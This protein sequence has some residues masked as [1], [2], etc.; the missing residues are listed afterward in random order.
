MNSSIIVVAYDRPASLTRLLMSLKKAV[1]KNFEQVRL[2]ISID[3]GGSES[4]K[5]IAEEFVWDYGAKRVIHHPQNLG[6]RKHILSCGD[7]SK[8]YGNVIIIEDD[9]VVSPQFYSFSE[10][11][12][13]FYSSDQNI[14]G[15]SLYSYK[16]NE[17]TF[18]PFQPLADSSDVYYMQIPS[19]WGQVWTKK[20]W[21]QFKNFYSQNPSITEQDQLPDQVKDW[22]ESSW[23]KYFYKYIV[24]KNLFIVFPKHSFT[25]NFADAGAHFVEGST[26]FQVPLFQTSGNANFNFITFEESWNKYDAYFEILP[27]ALTKL[28]V[29]SDENFGVDLYSTKQLHLFE[30]SYIYSLR[31]STNPIKTFGITMFPLIQNIISDEPGNILSYGKKESFDE[32]ETENYWQIRKVQQP[33]GFMSGERYGARK[34]MNTWSYKIGNVILHPHLYFLKL[35]QKIKM[36]LIHS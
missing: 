21:Q 28:G 24:V 9:C 15:I 11:A 36:R 33:F 2:I 32:V 35:F 14:A 13:K 4:V 18:L 31:K 10:Q 23:K 1:Y 3:G 6:L 25:T 7:L 27:E 17:Y 8:E 22:S 30:Y 26:F 12:L 19:S 34:V 5:T 29:V 16:V 20:Q